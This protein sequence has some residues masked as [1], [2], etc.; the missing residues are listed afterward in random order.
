MS[1]DSV[2]RVMNVDD[3]I[4]LATR[5]LG[6]CNRLSDDMFCLGARWIAATSTVL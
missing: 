2:G 4:S 5:G 6:V 3:R 1:D